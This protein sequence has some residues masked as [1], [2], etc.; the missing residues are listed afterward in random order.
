[1]L[2][3]VS[4]GIAFNQDFIVKSPLL[5]TSSPLDQPAATLGL[6]TGRKIIGTSSYVPRKPKLRISTELGCMCTS[7]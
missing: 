7:S 6:L 1:M 5:S 3:M 2:P 4:V